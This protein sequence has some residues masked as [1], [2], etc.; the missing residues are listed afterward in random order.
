MNDPTL[1]LA[2]EFYVDA[3]CET[4]NLDVIAGIDEMQT[5]LYKIYQEISDNLLEKVFEF[6][7]KVF[8]L[9]KESFLEL[10][11]RVKEIEKLVSLIYESIEFDIET[12]LD[13]IEDRIN[14][15]EMINV[16]IETTEGIEKITENSTVDEETSI[17]TQSN[18][19]NDATN[20]NV[21]Q[22]ASENDNLLRQS[23]VQSININLT[24]NDIQ[25]QELIDAIKSIKVQISNHPMSI[26]NAEKIECEGLSNDKKYELTEC[27]QQ[28]IDALNERLNMSGYIKELKQ[29]YTLPFSPEMET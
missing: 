13:S 9:F 16:K 22:M 19:I 2:L 8:N 29:S 12:K 28:D 27:Y 4:I 17:F 15:L 23:L 26:E 10:E 6:E 11:E 20:G 5:E 21:G 25:F 3:E 7:G 1:Q 14:E 18:E 24:L